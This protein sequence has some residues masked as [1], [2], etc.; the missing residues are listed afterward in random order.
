MVGGLPGR[1]PEQRQRQPFVCA[2]ACT[3]ADADS[4]QVSG[5]IGL[6]VMMHAHSWLC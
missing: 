6:H 5:L 3:G 4:F 2:G 1:V